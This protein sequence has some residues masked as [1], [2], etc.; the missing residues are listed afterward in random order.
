M[1]SVQQSTYNETVNFAVSVHV[2]LVCIQ[3]P[4]VP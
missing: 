3:D 2:V 1:V 4:Y